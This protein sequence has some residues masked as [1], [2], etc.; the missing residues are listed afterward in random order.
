MI[1]DLEKKHDFIGMNIND[2]YEILG[3]D[4]DDIYNYDNTL[5][6]FIGYDIFD[7]ALYCLEYDENN[8]IINTRN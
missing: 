4:Y 3:K 8:I 5:C 6:Y 7:I 1:E 2:V